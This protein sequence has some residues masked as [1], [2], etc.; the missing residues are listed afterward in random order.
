M[1]AVFS[2]VRALDVAEVGGSA[3]SGDGPFRHAGDRGCVVRPVGDRGVGDVVVVGHDH[4]LAEETAVF[5][6]AIGDVSCAVLGGDKLVLHFLREGESPDVGESA[7]AEEDAPH[8]GF[9]GV[10]CASETRVFGHDLREVSGAVTEAGSER[11]ERVEVVSEAGVD[12]DAPG[13]GLVE[14][15]LEGAEETSAAGDGL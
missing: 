7:G 9:R 3:V 13:R 6:V 15:E 8:A 5:E 11:G 12:A 4:D 2:L 14:R 1:V 10:G